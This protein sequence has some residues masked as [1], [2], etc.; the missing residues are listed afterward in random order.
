MCE[1]TKEKKNRAGN[2]ENYGKLQDTHSYHGI[3]RIIQTGFMK[4]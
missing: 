3:L 2:P 1:V 4:G